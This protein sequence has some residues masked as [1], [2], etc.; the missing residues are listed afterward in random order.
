MAIL[1]L[2]TAITVPVLA[3]S[4]IVQGRVFVFGSVTRRTP[5]AGPPERAEASS[6]A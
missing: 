4:V 2:A 1:V 3:Q 6:K 5:S